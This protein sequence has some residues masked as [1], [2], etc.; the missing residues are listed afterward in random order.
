MTLLAA[1]L[2]AAA[3]LRAPWSWIGGLLYIAYDTWLLSTLVSSSRRAVAGAPPAEPLPARRAPAGDR[4]PDRYRP[5][6]TSSS[7][8]VV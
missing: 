4:D 1:S 5:P 8:P 2:C 7:A 6:L 3:F